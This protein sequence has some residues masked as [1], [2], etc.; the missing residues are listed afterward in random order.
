MPESNQMKLE[1]VKMTFFTFM[2]F[3][4][5]QLGAELKEQAGNPFLRMNE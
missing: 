5:S 3:H 1:N 4:V 2:S